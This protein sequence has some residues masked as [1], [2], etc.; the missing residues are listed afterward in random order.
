[1]FLYKLKILFLSKL[2][3]VLSKF[4]PVEKMSNIPTISVLIELF[5]YPSE[6]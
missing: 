2:K 5:K 6:K 3:I 1:M 4:D